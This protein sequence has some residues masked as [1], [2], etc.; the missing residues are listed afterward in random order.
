MASALVANIRRFHRHKLMGH[1]RVFTLAVLLLTAACSVKE[2]GTKA[3]D[4][5]LY[6]WLGGADDH[7]P[8]SINPG[9]RAGASAARL[10]EALRVCG[11]NSFTVENYGLG[12]EEVWLPSSNNDAAIVGCVKK[13]IDFGFN[14]SRASAADWHEGKRG[15][16]VAPANGS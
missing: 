5:N 3:Q 13:H 8:E 1:C 6:L 7:V 2:S 4:P 14:A 10:G 11:V 12:G 15:H 16:I 9:R